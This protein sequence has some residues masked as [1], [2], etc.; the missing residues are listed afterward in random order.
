MYLGFK[1]DNG[2]WGEG[3]LTNECFNISIINKYNFN[4][5]EE[6]RKELIVK[7]LKYNIWQYY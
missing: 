1:A 2:E 5:R 6:G 7:I 3:A 4:S